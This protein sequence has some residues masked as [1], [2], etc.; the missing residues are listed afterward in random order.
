[1]CEE[2]YHR[3]GI[4]YPSRAWK[5]PNFLPRNL[6]LESDGPVMQ[7]RLRFLSRA[8]SNVRR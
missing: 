7:F 6:T 5:T 4:R 8:L 3:S 1:M 2:A